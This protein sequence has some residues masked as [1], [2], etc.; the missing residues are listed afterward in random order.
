MIS[1]FDE[2]QQ[3]NGHHCFMKDISE[4]KRAEAYLRQSEAIHAQL[5]AI[6]E[7]SDDALIRKGLDG[8]ILSWNRGAEKIFGYTAEEIVGQSIAMLIPPYRVNEIPQI[9]ERVRQGES[10]AHYDTERLRKDGQ[11]D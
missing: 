6:V 2:Q 5:A 4:R 10:V 7:A 11:T 1:A 3:F 9:L 8:T